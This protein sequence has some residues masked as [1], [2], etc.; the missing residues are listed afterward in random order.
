MS[1]SNILYAVARAQHDGLVLDTGLQAV[2]NALQVE[3]GVS[4]TA[5]MYCII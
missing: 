4:D 5:D 3:N 1:P 2:M